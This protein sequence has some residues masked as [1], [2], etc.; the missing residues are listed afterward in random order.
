MVVS[1]REGSHGIGVNKYTNP[2]RGDQIF[3][4]EDGIATLIR[5]G[6]RLLLE[7][8][9]TVASERLIRAKG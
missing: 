9:D 1:G 3:T 8:H 2:V 4:E 5:V 7:E 6:T